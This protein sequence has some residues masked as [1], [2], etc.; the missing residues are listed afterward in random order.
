MQYLLLDQ[1]HIIYISFVIT[2]ICASVV[3]NTKEFAK[4]SYKLK[5]L[6]L[7]PPH[8]VPYSDSTLLSAIPAPLMAP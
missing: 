6:S 7:M 1:N 2:V 8:E 4:D 5:L 3:Q